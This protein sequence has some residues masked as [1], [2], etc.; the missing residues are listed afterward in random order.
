MPS[1]EGGALEIAPPQGWDFK[2]AGNESLVAFVPAGS[3]VNNL[4]RILVSVE[5]CPFPDFAD[6][7]AGNVEQFTAKLAGTLA[8]KALAGEAQPLLLG[9]NAFARYVAFAR[10]G[11]ATVANQHLVT[12]QNGHMY[13][14]RLESYQAQFQAHRDA[15]YA[16]GASMKFSTPAPDPA[17]PDI[18]PASTTDEDGQ[19]PSG[20]V[21]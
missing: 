2:R 7:N 14:V 15:G 10:Q 9:D 21:D 13:T 12:S 16:V 5:D 17:L 4:P 20:S 18:S 6:V 1:L 19:G 11:N 3:T 8:D